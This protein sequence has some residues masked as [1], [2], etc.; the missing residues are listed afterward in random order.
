MTPTDPVQRFIGE[1]HYCADLIEKGG[2]RNVP[3]DAMRS[4]FGVQA[5]VARRAGLCQLERI[6]SE[7]RSG[8]LQGADAI[9]A[10]RGYAAC[11]TKGVE[12]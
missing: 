4:Y 3:G 12:S 2:D 5:V 11:C 10:L 6:F 7:M 8:V 9:A 1:C